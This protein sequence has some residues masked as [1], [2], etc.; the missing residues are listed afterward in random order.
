MKRIFAIL[1]TSALLINSLSVGAAESGEKHLEAST[2]WL[3]ADLDSSHSYNGWV[4]TRIG[5]G[6]TL[7]KLND[8]V[9]LQPWI[10]DSWENVDEL[11]W[12]IHIRDGITFHNGKAVDAEA[13]RAS[14]QY[15]Y[16]NNDRA[17]T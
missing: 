1:L 3:T 13:A 6:E 10:A 7:I 16:D 11:T 12:K 5:I 9:E 14:L 4:C 8:Q 15:A 17:D 2:F